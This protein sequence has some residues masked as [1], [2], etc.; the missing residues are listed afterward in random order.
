MMEFYTVK[1]K[2]IGYLVIGDLQQYNFLLLFTSSV[3]VSDKHTLYI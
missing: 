3:N 2:N 1:E